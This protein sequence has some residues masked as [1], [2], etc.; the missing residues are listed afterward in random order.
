[1]T[2]VTQ[3]LRPHPFASSVVSRLTQAALHR[4]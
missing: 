2:T 1:M 3:L 4:Y